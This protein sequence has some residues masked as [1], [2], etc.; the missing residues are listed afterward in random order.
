MFDRPRNTLVYLSYSSKLVDG[1]PM[2]SV[3]AVPVMPWAAQ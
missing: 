3:A 1:S 2:N